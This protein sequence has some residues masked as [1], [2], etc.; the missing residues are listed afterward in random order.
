MM[1]KLD[2]GTLCCVIG[3]ICSIGSIIINLSRD[4]YRAKVSKSEIVIEKDDLAKLHNEIKD[5]KETT[6]EIKEL[7]EIVKELKTKTAKR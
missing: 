1:D 6:K 7:R 2:N 3:I 4:G 5:L